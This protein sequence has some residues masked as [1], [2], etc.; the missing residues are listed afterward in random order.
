MFLGL[1]LPNNNRFLAFVCKENELM[2]SERTV[3]NVFA[4]ARIEEVVED[5]V[6]L[7]RSGSN[8]TGLCPFHDEKTPS[9]MVSPGKNIY[10]CFGCGRGG[11]P[12]NFVMEHEKFS[13]PEAIKQL[14][15]KYHITIEETEQSDEY[16]QEKLLV[17][18]YY[19]INEFAQAYF[20][21]NLF[22]S[23]EG[24]SIGLS[25]FKERG[26][27]DK[28]IKTF[29][30]GYAPYDKTEFIKKA[31]NAQYKEEYLMGVGLMSTRKFDFFNQRV[32]FPIHNMTGRVIGFAGRIL[33]ANKKAPKYINSKES[34]IYNKR[35]ILY[36]MYQA[37]DQIRKQDA[38]FLVEGYTDV[39]SMNQT[40]VENV[41]ASS[42][43]SLTVG[44]VK[45]VKRFTENLFMLFDGDNAG[46]KA[47]MRGVD[48]ALEQDMNVKVVMLPE[49]EDPDD[50]IA[51]IDQALG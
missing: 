10:K 9:F 20:V 48:L 34:E 13:F 29:G 7:R 26:F 5:Y 45:L 3:D 42:G 50:L 23:E 37:K 32:M 12:V 40:G 15:G 17:E 16:K 39:I 46:I 31:M 43:T 38:C 28:T 14:A 27:I 36:G 35:S 11:N 25:Y 33:T 30:L 22:E 1:S 2:I 47:A 51:D 18:S 41:V 19:I 44:Q 4:L 6:T 49:G 8:F 24:K 21:K